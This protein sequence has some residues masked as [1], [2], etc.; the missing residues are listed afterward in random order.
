MDWKKSTEPKG[1]DKCIHNEDNSY[2]YMCSS[3][4]EDQVLIAT[5]DGNLI[6]SVNFPKCLANFFTFDI[7]TLSEVKILLNC[8]NDNE[9]RYFDE[10]DVGFTG[11]MNNAKNQSHS[12]RKNTFAKLLGIFKLHLRLSDL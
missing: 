2:S 8:L 3:G 9:K 1:I 5:K 4:S 12:P 6:I 10:E 11:L 7:I